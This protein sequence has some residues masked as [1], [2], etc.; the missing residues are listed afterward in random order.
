MDDPAAGQDLRR[1]GA[2][3]LRTN[4]HNEQ[5]IEGMLALAESDRGLQGKV[6]VRLDEL[7]GT[8]DR[9]SMRSWPQDP[10]DPA[11]RAGGR[12][13]SRATRCCSSG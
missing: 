12:P 2:Q 3:L 6:P 8:G 5:L 4:E 9:R 7:A 13:P 1:L 10:G 11:P